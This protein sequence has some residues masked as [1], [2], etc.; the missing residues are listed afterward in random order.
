MISDFTGTLFYLVGYQR[1]KINDFFYL[2]NMNNFKTLIL[3]KPA[4]EY[5]NLMFC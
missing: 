1:L 4:C 3:L 5:S 2:K